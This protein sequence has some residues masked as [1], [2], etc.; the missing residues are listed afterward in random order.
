MDHFAR[1]DDELLKSQRDEIRHTIIQ[2]IMCRG[3]SD[4][5]QLSAQL[6][7]DFNWYFLHE[8]LDLQVL[9]RDGLIKL[10][11]DSMLVTP[12][13]RLLLRNIAMVFDSYLK[14]TTQQQ[15]S[16]AV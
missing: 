1:A 14:H 4:F 13:G 2:H 3:Y 8:T 10:D 6:N 12:K 9:Q 15:F 5:K 7:I 11:D 16:K